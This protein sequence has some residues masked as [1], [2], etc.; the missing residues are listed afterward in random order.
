MSEVEGRLRT[1]SFAGGEAKVV[2]GMLVPMLIPDP[3]DKNAELYDINWR[4]FMPRLG[5]AYRI[6]DRTVLRTGAG[7]FYNA[8][9]MNNFQILNLQPPF[10][11]SNLFEND[12]TNPRATIDN[13]FAGT[14]T[15][16]PAALL[17]LGNVQ[18]DR[19]NRSMYL[20]N[21]I[22]Q[23][24]MELEH[25][26]GKELVTGIAYLGRKGSN[27]RHHSKQFQQPYTGPGSHPVAP[28]DAVF[29]GIARTR[30]AAATRYRA[31][32]GQRHELQLQC[33]PAESRKTLLQWFTFTGSSQL[34]ERDWRWLQRE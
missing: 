16:S 31:L 14:S 10:S 33:V 5:I 11:G 29:R 13:P 6:S 25:S 3:L 21:D 9:Q 1:L 22:W 30:Q 34:S 28:T 4:Q 27:I 17:M 32:L 19:N 18:A 23:W 26:F 24:T 7:L 8:Q 2:N 12:R 15:Q 20:N